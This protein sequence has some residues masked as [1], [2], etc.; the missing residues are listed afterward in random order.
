MNDK[1]HPTDT[2]CRSGKCLGGV[3]CDVVNCTYNDGRSHCYAGS[4]SVGPQ[5]ADCCAET[6]C[7]T[8][9]PKTY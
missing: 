1:K 4:I 9:K 3:M 5:S 2:S 6:V 8:F 7:S